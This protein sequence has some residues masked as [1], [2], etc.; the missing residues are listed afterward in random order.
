MI[1]SCKFE[2]N[3]TFQR[4]LTFCWNSLASFKVHLLHPMK[5]V[6]LTTSIKKKSFFKKIT[7]FVY[8][9]FRRWIKSDFWCS[10]LFTSEFSEGSICELHTGELG[11]CKNANK[12]HWLINNLKR[13][14]MG[15]GDI[16]RCS[17]TVKL[18]VEFKQ[19]KTW[20]S[21]ISHFENKKKINIFFSHRNAG[22]TWRNN[23]LRRWA[24]NQADRS[25]SWTLWTWIF[26]RVNIWTLWI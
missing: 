24:S 14:K 4:V 7:I 12:C 9:R 3:S 6:G 10:F 23:L 20:F 21:I 15:Y 22:T 5:L 18:K 11:V 8:F 26:I 25:E 1:L 2:E 17:F 16:R 13:H 19:K